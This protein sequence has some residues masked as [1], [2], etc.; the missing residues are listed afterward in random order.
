MVFLQPEKRTYPST[1]HNTREQAKA[2]IFDYI[3]A[4]YNR[5]RHHSYLGDVSPEEFERTSA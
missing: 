4:S 5:I 3:E 1:S 2:D